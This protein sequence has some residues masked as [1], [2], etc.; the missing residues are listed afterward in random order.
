MKN[1]I[2]TIICVMA[3]H[4]GYAQTY[5]FSRTMETYS[6]LENDTVIS[7]DGW[8]RRS[9]LL[10]SPFTI[11]VNNVN[12]TEMW[13]NTD[14]F[15]QRRTGA[16]SGSSFAWP[17][18]GAGLRQKAGAEPSQISYVVEGDS[19]QRI[20]KLQYKNVGFVGDEYHEDKANFQVWFYEGTRRVEFRYGPNSM[21]VRRAL[22]GGYG[23]LVSF[24]NVNIRG[25]QSAPS[26]TTSTSHTLN[27]VP[28]DGTVYRFQAP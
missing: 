14:G 15:I 5:T 2:L 8:V 23:P 7:T 3:L 25:P 21:N 28:I 19:P 6:E 20:L 13:V 24:S 1:I 9:F 22:N 11:R 26:T 4:F 27:G 10:R 17:F 18:W 12:F 16:N